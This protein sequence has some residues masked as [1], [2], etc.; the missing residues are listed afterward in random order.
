LIGGDGADLL[1]GA[2]GE[3]VLVA[4]R[5]AFDAA[6]GGLAHQEALMAL[7]AEWSSNRDYATRVD[8]L[9]GIG[10]GPRLNGSFY[11]NDD[12]VFDDDD[13]DLLLGGSGRDWF[14]RQSWKDLLLDRRSNER[15]N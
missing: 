14:L 5:T 12:T 2:G 3:D 4:G 9:K 11:L 6:G 1:Y 7:L 13:L 10:A 8:N 15:I